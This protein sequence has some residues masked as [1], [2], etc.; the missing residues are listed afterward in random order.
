MLKHIEDDCLTAD[1]ARRLAGKCNFPTGRLF[2][3]VGCAP[4][5]A[6]Y[7]RRHCSHSSID[8]PTRAALWSLLDIIRHYKPMRI[9]RTPYAACY[10]VIH[11]DA[12]F[13]LGQSRLRPGDNERPETFPDVRRLENGW[14]AVCFINGDP[15]KL[16]YFQGRLPKE[17]LLQFSNA[18]SFI[19]LLE[20]WVSMMAPIVFAP[21]LETFYV[22]CCD[23]EAAR[24][25]LI[26]GVGKHQ[27]L[28]CLI[29]AHWT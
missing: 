20:A 17:I 21:C 3:K 8:K 27:P 13:K 11:T 26:K 22:Q 14:G 23:N 24:H 25:A 16:A 6:I 12:Y 5:K 29:D 9:P 10:S 19:Y 15:Y 7:V 2:G 1:H 28:N 4:L 18:Q